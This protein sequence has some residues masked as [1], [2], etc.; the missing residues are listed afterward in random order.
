L[1]KT[2]DTAQQEEVESDWDEC[3]RAIKKAKLP[4]K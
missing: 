4:K 1:K 3:I 2:L